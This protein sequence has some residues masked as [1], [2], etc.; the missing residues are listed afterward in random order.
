MRTHAGSAPQE[1]SESAGACRQTEVGTKARNHSPN[2]LSPNLQRN[3]IQQE[4]RDGTV[5]FDGPKGD[6]NGRA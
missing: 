2:G 1:C 3:I 5:I 4:P 6:P